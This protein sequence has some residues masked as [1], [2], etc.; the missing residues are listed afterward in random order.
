VSE[1]RV[2]FSGVAPAPWRSAATERVIT[3]QRLTEDVVRRAA[4]AAVA[5]ADPMPDNA[6]KVDLLRGVL[7]Q[8]LAELV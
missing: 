3:G 4:E 2:V 8:E 7:A 1:A 5:E 6:Y